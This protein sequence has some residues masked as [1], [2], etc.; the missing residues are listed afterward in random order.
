MTQEKWDRVGEV[1]H[2]AMA[3]APEN[4]AAFLDQACAGDAELRR[5]IESLLARAEDASS[6]LETP[7]LELAGRAMAAHRAPSLVGRRLGQYEIRSFIGAGGMGEVYLAR[8]RTLERDVAVKCLPTY[9][10]SDPN[11][12]ARLRREARLLATLNHPNIASI[13]G[14]EEDDGVIGL[15][16]ELVEGPNL[17]ERSGI[18]SLKEALGIAR[19]IADAL[20][21]AHEKGIIHRDLKPTNI[22]VTPSGVVKVLDFGLAKAL[23]DGTQPVEELTD[24][25]TRAGAILGTPAYMSPEQARGKK[26]DRRTD[27]W[28][29]G[30]VLYELIA[31]RSAFGDDNPTDSLV[32]VLESDPDWK[33]L[34]PDTPESIRRVL[35]RCLEKDV[36]LR[37][38]DIAD[39]RLEIAEALMP[40][41]N[42]GAPASARRRR[43]RVLAQIVAAVLIVAAGAYV[44]VRSAPN[45]SVGEVTRLTFRQGTVGKARFAPDGQTVIYGA[46]W[47]G[48]PYRLYSTL[49]GGGHSRTIDLPAADLLAVSKQGQIALSMGRPAVDG[50][51]PAGTLAVTALAGG[52]PRELYDNVVGADWSADGKTMAIVRRTGT[53]ARLEYPVGTIIHQATLILPP[54]VSP[55]GEHVCFFAGQAYGQLMVADRAGR[56]RQLANDLYRGGHCAWTPD[57]REIWVDAGGGAMHMSL[58]AFDLAGKRRQIANYTGMIHLE[59]IAPDGTVLM[60]A[61]T[62]RYSVHAHD[63]REDRERDLTVFD[64]SRVHH[65]IADGRQVLMWDNSPAAGKDFVFRR[66]VDGMPAVPVGPG[67]PAALT[68][69]GA[70]AAVVGDGQTNTRIQNKLTLFPTGAGTARTFDLPIDVYSAYSGVLGRTD[71]A[72]R[73]H[74]FSSDG[75]RL[76]FPFGIA[77]GRPPRVYVYDL[78][79]RVMKPITPEGATGPAVISPDGTHVAVNEMS[80]VVVY[81]VDDDQRQPLAGAPEPG[82]VAAWSADGRSLFVIEQDET[83]ARIFRRDIVT[84]KRTLVHEIRAQSPAGVTSFDVFVSRNG[85]AYAYTTSLRLANVFIVSGL[86]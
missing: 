24:A 64:A 75:T 51:E 59:D 63:G 56:V 2:G 85:E 25:R 17:D 10:A 72:R 77:K 3:I 26:V 80:H 50:W 28:A 61:G 32:R 1:Y 7:A 38:R 37:L 48:E 58:L 15:V 76:L 53:T 5:E 44:G 12:R 69:D 8:D 57:G 27:V 46:S 42:E 81:G 39:A 55:D 78:P 62:L 71:W 67:W 41:P 35:R 20:E 22:K 66:A 19:Q 83:V 52:A 31:G 73:S 34:P 49:V 36:S 6:F 54:R 9:V 16:L 14:V 70:W 23:E 45:A 43:G 65:V 40:R 82:K 74:D 86:R 4:R 79:R 60:S 18:M 29:F 21:A 84:G 68:A 13:H 11:A 47:D 33:A 30:C